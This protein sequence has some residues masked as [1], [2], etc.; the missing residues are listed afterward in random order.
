LRDQGITRPFTG[1]PA[2][3]TYPPFDDTARIGA[4]IRT[5]MGLSQ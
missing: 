5:R 4:E 2:H 3:W 1:S